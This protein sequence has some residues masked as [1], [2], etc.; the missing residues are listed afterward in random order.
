MSVGNEPE[1]ATSTHVVVDASTLVNTDT[2]SDQ[3]PSVRSSAVT[4]PEVR[5]F[6]AEE[7]YTQTL[8]VYTTKDEPGITALSS[9]PHAT[10]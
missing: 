9:V 1:K 6:D 5:E 3:T 8:V 4:L 2:A 10:S 7:V